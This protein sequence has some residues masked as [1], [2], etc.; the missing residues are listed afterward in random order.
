M[1]VFIVRDIDKITKS[2]AVESAKAE[3]RLLNMDFVTAKAQELSIRQQRSEVCCSVFLFIIWDYGI[4]AEV[5]SGI[6]SWSFCD[7]NSNPH[8][9]QVG[10]NLILDK[11]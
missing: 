5:L 9:P 10:I 4:D 11:I 2:Q 7:L 6:I 3:E 1:A 8:Y